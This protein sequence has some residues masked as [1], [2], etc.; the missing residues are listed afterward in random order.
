MSVIFQ[1]QPKHDQLEDYVRFAKEN[2]MAFEIIDLSMGNEI[3][4]SH[5]QDYAETG[6]VKSFHGV[7]IDVNPVS[8]NSAIKA[9][10]R[11]QFRE[12][13]ELAKR[14]GAE[15]I[16]FHSSCF[17]F[18]RDSYMERWSSECAKYFDSLQKETGLNIFIE[19]SFDVDC[20]PLKTL[21]DKCPNKNVGIC[22]DIGHANFSRKA[23]NEWFLAL[24]ERIGYIHLSDNAGYFDRHMELGSGS[25]D[26]KT[27]D[28]L[29][30]RLS[31]ISERDIP[32]TIE[33]GSLE[34]A[35]RSYEF[36]KKNSYFT[37]PAS[38]GAFWDVVSEEASKPK[39]PSI[40]D[41]GLRN[42]ILEQENRKLENAIDRYLSKAIAKRLMETPEG[43]SLGGKKQRLTVMMSDLRSFTAISEKMA[44][45]DLL[46]MLN[47]YLGEMT[48]L[49]NR[50]RGT[51]IEF[52]GDGIL[53]IF[54]TPIESETHAS[55]AVKAAVDMQNAMDDI[56]RWNEKRGFPSLRMGIGIC[57]GSMIVGNIGS[58]HHAKFG[59]LGSTVNL[60]GRIEGYTSGGQ[61]YIC[62]ETRED[63]KESL[64]ID[65]SLTVLPKGVNR[66]L[67][68]HRISGINGVS[69]KRPEPVWEDLPSPIEV[70]F[71]R[72]ADKNVLNRI[73]SGSLTARSGT[74]M[75]LHTDVA[76][77][78]SDELRLSFGASKDDAFF[79]VVAILND[80]V[81]RIEQ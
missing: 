28:M 74:A 5:V 4:I 75:L 57:T 25:V 3:D 30:R 10:S 60:C 11:N 14:L 46:E 44:A 63:I 36:L 51:V 48:V 58:V 70:T 42:E 38:E 59:V 47:H 32:I 33:V 62:P 43:M 39:R 81:Y 66:E 67:I 12:S 78:R 41:L 68:I 21:M 8:N 7:F 55:D 16:V 20:D 71:R 45:N 6:L 15:N 61:I 34:D 13:C 69:C 17:P 40:E 24:G 65:E 37:G 29:F 23:L 18:L 72:V 50:Y 22:L 19:N 26:W 79:K 9:V 27:A 77:G 56:N 80:G 73:F 2:G 53:A 1:L 31:F 64:D 52:I 76:L 54:G 35:Q 49:I